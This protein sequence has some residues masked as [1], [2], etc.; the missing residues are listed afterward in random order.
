MPCYASPLGWSQDCPTGW[1]H[2]YLTTYA[3]LLSP[4]IL[5]VAEI[6]EIPFTLLCDR[7]LTFTQLLSITKEKGLGFTYQARS[8]Y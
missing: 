4:E 7:A 5:N 6:C 2:K 3:T 1:A 8:N